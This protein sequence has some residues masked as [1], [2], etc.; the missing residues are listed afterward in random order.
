[1]KAFV[2]TVYPRHTIRDMILRDPANGR[3][4]L[5]WGAPTLD[6]VFNRPDQTPVSVYYADTEVDALKMASVLT[7]QKSGAVA[8]VSKTTHVVQTNVPANFKTTVAQW[9]E[10]GLLPV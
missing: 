7:S 10:K 6:G 9:T 3:D 4:F 1:M 5:A 8:L 2:I